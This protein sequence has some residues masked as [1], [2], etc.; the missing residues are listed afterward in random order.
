[1]KILYFH[2]HFSVPSGS[3]G[4][5][6]YEIAKRMTGS[7]HSVV[8]V[9]GK[10][11]G[12]GINIEGESNR[13]EARGKVGKIEVIQLNLPYS[14][15]DGFFRRSV[16]FLRFA[17]RSIRIA[18]KEPHDVLF[19]TSTPLTAALPGIAARWLKGSRFVFEVRDLWPELPVAMGVIRN[20]V[21]V[22]S[23]RVLEWMAYFSAHGVVGLSPGIL[24]GIQKR[25]SLKKPTI[26]VPN[27]SDL[28]LFVPGERQES[29]KQQTTAVFTG[30]HGLAN[31]LD[32]V[33]DA[34]LELISRD[35]V[36]IRLI[37]DGSQKKRLEQ[38]A[39]DEGIANCE[40]K[41][42]I[43]KTDLAKMLSKADMGL[44]ILADVPAFYEGTSPNKF[45]DYL[46]AGLPV[47][48]NYPGW[49]ADI[50]SKERCG[51]PVPP[52]D[53]RALAKAISD[54]ADDPEL[55]MKIGKRAREV[56]EAYFD[57]DQQADRLIKFVLKCAKPD[58]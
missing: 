15:H 26:M 38:R 16:T 20:P 19:A 44:M 23:L 9:C 40:F 14:N 1:M 30:A 24:K 18:L 12:S 31:G 8:M 34:A 49:V 5:R 6:S 57:R 35:D 41:H 43:P 42:P 56:A 10:Y 21:I 37:G 33:L 11:S 13:I 36:S 53:P 29:G 39:K 45:F 48:V 46:S 47:V 7:G 55:R 25:S 50:V 58:Q 27:G 17:W 54:L 22:L 52:D 32:A 3:G 4:T 51:I 2:Q 28:S